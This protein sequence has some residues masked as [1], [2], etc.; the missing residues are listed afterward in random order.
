M[1]KVRI[2]AIQM[3]D[4]PIP[5]DCNCLSDAFVADADYVL[6][7]NVL[8]QAEVTY[9][10]LE[11]AG[12]AGMD[13]VTTGEDLC[14]ISHYIIDTSSLNIFPQL[15]RLSAPLAEERISAIAKKYRMNIVAC[16]MKAYGDKIYNLASLFDRSGQIVG[17]YRKTHLP[18]NEMWQV[19]Q[20]ETAPV[21]EMDFGRVGV[22]ICYD[23]MFPALSEALSLQGAEVVFHPTAGYGW[24]DSIGEATLRTRANDNSL[25]IVTSKN[26]CYNGAGRSSVVDHWGQILSDAGF[27]A[28]VIVSAE[29]DLDIPKTQPDWH[30]QTG[31]TGEPNMVLRRPGERRPDLYGILADTSATPQSPPSIAEQERI[32]ERVKSGEF[33]W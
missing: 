20:G 5:Q 32:R 29:V 19:T 21:F 11:K 8:A 31:I 6:R 22:E 30:Y 27:Y 33:H 24:Y 23:M 2:G 1:R 26:Y 17:E 9:D 25:Y 16:Y 7:H 15:T 4:L 14:Q 10:L 18:P 3:A 28:N 12:A 13:A